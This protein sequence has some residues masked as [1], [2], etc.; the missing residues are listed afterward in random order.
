[1]NEASVTSFTLR[2]PQSWRTHGGAGT[3][4]TYILYTLETL[5]N[6]ANSTKTRKTGK[7]GGAKI[8]ET[9]GKGKMLKNGEKQRKKWKKT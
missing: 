3:I 6:C 4:W 7:T 8:G 9:L 5:V 2:P 1:M